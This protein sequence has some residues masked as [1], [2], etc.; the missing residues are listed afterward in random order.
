MKYQKIIFVCTSNTSRSIMAERIYKSLET[1]SDVQVISRGLV[2][3]FPEP[4]NPKAAIVMK[5]HN[6][7]ID[8]YEAV[9]LKGEDIEEET[10]IL[11]MTE[12]Q[13]DNVMEEY[14]MEINVFPLK[15]YVGES[16][17]VGDPYGQTLV[18]Y[19]ECYVELARL[20]KKAVYKLNEE[21]RSFEG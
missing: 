10:L 6:L 21:G 3:L 14:G 18:E 8:D 17:E 12:Q 16:G 9:L 5:N 4:V 2:V 7:P 13:R 20:I 1:S 15:E 19:E 11:T